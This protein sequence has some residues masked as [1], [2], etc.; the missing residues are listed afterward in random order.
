MCEC[1]CMCVAISLI[2]TK[3]PFKD[4]SSHVG[5]MDYW[6]FCLDVYVHMSSYSW[7]LVCLQKAQRTVFRIVIDS[8]SNMTELL[9]GNA[10]FLSAIA[11]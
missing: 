8:A 1:V 6:L 7:S 4:G 5:A 11:T 2:K 9:E 3:N 10:P